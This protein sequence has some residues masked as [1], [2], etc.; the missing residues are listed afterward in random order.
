MWF[1]FRDIIKNVQLPYDQDLLMEL[2]T[3]EWKMDLK[4]R[5]AVESKDLFKKR[6]FRSPDKAD[7]LLLAFYQ[8]KT[9]RVEIF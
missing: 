6:G 3:R 2:S 5:R 9:M 1:E 7:A 8:P 4:G